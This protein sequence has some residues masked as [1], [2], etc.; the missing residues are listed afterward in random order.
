MPNLKKDNFDACFRED[1]EGTGDFTTCL[2][3]SRQWDKLDL[4][5]GAEIPGRA[6]AP[7]RGSVLPNL[8]WATP[9]CASE[10]TARERTI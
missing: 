1:G 6:G 7:L 2:A 9:V 5:N 8:K 4:N 10:K 3:S